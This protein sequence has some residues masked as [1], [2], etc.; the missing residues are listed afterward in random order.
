MLN[1][2]H[3]KITALWSLKQHDWLPRERS[4]TLAQLHQWEQFLSPP[5]S[6]YHGDHP[7]LHADP[8]HLFTVPSE[9][10]LFAALHILEQRSD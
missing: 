4:A 5:Q 1:Y 10:L 9:S 8:P 2:T 3:S 7:L 6:S